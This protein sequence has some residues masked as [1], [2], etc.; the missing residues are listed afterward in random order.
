MYTELAILCG[1]ASAKCSR[2]YFGSYGL[3]ESEDLRA[4]C[5]LLNDFSSSGPHFYLA[6]ALSICLRGY[7]VLAYASSLSY[8]NFALNCAACR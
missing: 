5:M 6:L 7:V 1:C 4:F 3:S 2:G 8:I